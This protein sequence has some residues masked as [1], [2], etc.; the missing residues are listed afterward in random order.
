MKEDIVLTIGRS[1]MG[2]FGLRGCRVIEVVESRGDGSSLFL[3]VM[4][5]EVRWDGC[6]LD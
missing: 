4:V 2:V 5:V 6:R 3:L 1:V